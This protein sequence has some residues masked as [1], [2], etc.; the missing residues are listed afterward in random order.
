MGEEITV[1]YVRINGENLIFNEHNCLA[2]YNEGRFDELCNEWRKVIDGLVKNHFIESDIY[3]KSFLNRFFQHFFYI[4]CQDRFKF[5]Q[6]Q[7]GYFIMANS[8]ISNLV[9]I[10]D[11]RTTDIPLS[12]VMHQ[13]QNYNKILVLLNPYNTIKF[14]MKQIFDVDHVSASIWFFVNLCRTY[15]LPN[16]IAYENLK[17]F[18]SCPDD[19]LVILGDIVEN[20]RLA[21]FTSTYIDI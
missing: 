15:L 3:M 11:Y 9:C 20:M 6:P 12:I 21:F 13:Q 10:S 18:Q 17:I 8:Y 19:R 14:D 16:K 1:S 5:P 7:M 4:I 2:L